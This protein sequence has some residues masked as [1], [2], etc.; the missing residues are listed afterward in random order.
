MT[1]NTTKLTIIS[2]AALALGALA[3]AAI[4]AVDGTITACYTKTLTLSGPKGSLRVLNAPRP[5]MR[6]A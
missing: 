3:Y 1:R 4:P 6:L 5:S 2:V